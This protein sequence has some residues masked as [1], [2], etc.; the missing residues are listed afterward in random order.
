MTPA[1]RPCRGSHRR[2]PR[3]TY[4]ASPTTGAVKQGIVAA[5]I[6]EVGL[7]GGSSDHEGFHRRSW[8]R[9]GQQQL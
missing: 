4:R 9:G 8:L 5:A 1:P 2:R 6:V 7:G 3:F